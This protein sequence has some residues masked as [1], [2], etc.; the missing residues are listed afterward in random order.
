MTAGCSFGKDSFSTESFLSDPE[1]ENGERAEDSRNIDWSFL[2]ENSMEYPEADEEQI[3]DSYYYTQI[4]ED[5]QLLYRQIVYGIE[6]HM[7]KFSVDAA[8]EDMPHE[9]FCTVLMDHP[10]YFWLS[11]ET[12]LWEINKGESYELETAFNMEEEQIDVRKQ[13][14]ENCASEFLNLVPESSDT[15]TKVKTAY[16]WII[17][18]TDY[19]DDSEENQNIQSVFLRHESVCAGYAKSFQYLMDCMDIPCIYVTG[20]TNGESH[21]WNIVEIDGVYAVVDCTWGDPNFEDEEMHENEAIL[22]DYFCLTT[23][24][25]ERTHTADPKYTCPDCTDSS[26]DY[27][28]IQGEYFETYEEDAL[29]EVCR[30]S[31]LNGGYQ[32]FIKFGSEE[33]FRQAAAAI[34]EGNVL[35]DVAY[36]KMEQDQIEEYVYTYYC[37]E[38]LWI[39]KMFW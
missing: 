32:T 27:Y 33:A 12:T 31:L 29:V 37:D 2:Y 13:Q 4:D 20:T 10:E 7:E 38:N 21:A 17:N 23:E 15:Y 3:A 30:D 26:Y 19:V 5:E 25:I 1:E 36:E 34:D 8:D 35:E 22:Y 18:Q 39:I 6:N 14:I 16:E 9:I 28:R 11:G 24:E